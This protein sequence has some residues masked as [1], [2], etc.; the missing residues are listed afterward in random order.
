MT[1]QTRVLTGRP[2]SGGGGGGL[3]PA[4][5]RDLDQLVHHVAESSFDEYIYNGSQLVSLTTWADGT[6]TRKIR[7]SLFTYNGGR[8]QQVVTT[9]HDGSGAVVETL[10]EIFTY[11][12][13]R[14]T[15][16][17]RVLT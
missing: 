8:L 7:E 11:T 2:S 10:T 17:D 14:V 15:S 9:Q 16:I 6:K 13:A 3:T 1:V 5:H 12:V 4:A